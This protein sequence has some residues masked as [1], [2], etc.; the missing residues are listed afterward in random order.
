MKDKK[1]SVVWNHWFIGK[2]AM[3]FCATTDTFFSQWRSGN[4][5]MLIL[6]LLKWLITNSWDDAGSVK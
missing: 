2:P 4:I 3:S 1:D 6:G 5:I